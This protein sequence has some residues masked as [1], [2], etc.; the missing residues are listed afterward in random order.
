MPR[1]CLIR[2]LSGKY[3]QLTRTLLTRVPYFLFGLFTFLL[4]LIL[5]NGEMWTSFMKTLF[6]Y[7]DKPLYDLYRALYS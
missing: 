3:S 7:R 5:S 2:I 6:D 4:F 1:N